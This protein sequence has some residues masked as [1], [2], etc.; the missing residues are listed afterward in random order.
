VGDIDLGNLYRKY[1]EDYLKEN[2]GHLHNNFMQWLVTLGIVGFA[3]VI[4][5]VVSILLMH[6]KIYRTLKNEPV[7]SSV[8]I[9]AI[10]TFIG[11]L[12][13]GLG[14]YNFGDQEIITMVWFT[15]GLNLAFYLNHKNNNGKAKA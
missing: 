2:F 15:V 12:A 10:A 3:S 13:S 6:L 4:F 9:A 7:A 5:M 11:F 14:E 8:A 1:K